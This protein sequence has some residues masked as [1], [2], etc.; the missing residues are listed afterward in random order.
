VPALDP[1]SGKLRDCLAPRA[2]VSPP[3]QQTLG[4]D[5][6]RASSRVS[7][8]RSHRTSL[9]HFGCHARRQAR[10]RHVLVAGHCGLTGSPSATATTAKGEASS[11]TLTWTNAARSR[12]VSRAEDFV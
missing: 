9:R 7:P 12:D 11:L 1:V 6:Q 2:G 3:A 10:G 4:V 5:E 8:T